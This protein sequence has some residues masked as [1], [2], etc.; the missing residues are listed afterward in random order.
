MRRACFNYSLRPSVDCHLRGDSIDI[1]GAR[2]KDPVTEK[3]ERQH[4]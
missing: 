2:T 3:Q 1:V 4:P